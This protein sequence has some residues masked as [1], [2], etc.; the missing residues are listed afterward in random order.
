[1]KVAAIQM[2]SGIVVDD[3][4][5]VAQRLLE[6]AAAQGAELV[7]LPEYFCLMGQRDED[8]IGIAEA[9]GEGPLQRFLSEQ[10]RALKM[11][12]VGGSIPLRTA[13]ERRVTNTQLVFN[14]QGEQVARYDK[15]HLFAFSRGAESY[16]ESR[17]QQ[18]GSQ[19]VTFDLSSVDGNTW[20]IGLSTCYDLRFPELYRQLGAD[21]LLVPSAFTFTTG[22]A[23]WEIL[24][25][26]RAIENLAYVLA[27]AQGGDHENGRRTW[28]QSL[29]INPWGK[30]LNQLAEGE[31][32][33]V[34]DCDW[35]L[36]QEM[37]QQLPALQHRQ[38]R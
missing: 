29:I 4:L 22:Q 14:P 10:A 37:R 25:R 11:W 33:V 24:L 9:P 20:R 8:K 19:P 38:F 16:D 12:L 13:D 3:N 26:A 6:Q 7:A 17:V 1:M 2:V 36:M 27:P 30:V 34:A 5:L 23:H 31:G 28:G 15:I 21:L 35:A 32:V 18:G